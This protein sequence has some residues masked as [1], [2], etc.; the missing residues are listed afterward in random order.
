MHDF[1]QALHEWLQ[2]LDP[3]H[4]DSS[5]VCCCWD[6]RSVYAREMGLLDDDDVGR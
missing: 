6:C 2:E 5:C 1:L 4:D 3:T